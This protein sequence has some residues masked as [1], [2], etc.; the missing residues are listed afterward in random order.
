[1]KN[2]ALRISRAKLR[3]LTYIDTS[4]GPDAC[5]PYTRGTDRFGHGR[6]W[7][8]GRT[9]PAH[10]VLWTIT[11]DDP[12][13]LCVLHHCDNPPCCNVTHLF[14]G[15]KSD[16]ALDRHAK[17]RTR[18]VFGEAQGSAKLKEADI[19]DIRAEYARGQFQRLIALRYGVSRSTIGSIVTGQHWR[20][21]ETEA[22]Q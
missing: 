4:N 12:G 7:F 8:E 16:N 19:R 13:E 2:A 21:V 17:G 5:H 20:R 3:L 15:T 6:F 22:N 11:Q 14:L 18:F 10:R 9:R 1:M